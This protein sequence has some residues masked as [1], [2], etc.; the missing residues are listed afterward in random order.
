MTNETA[1][2]LNDTQR[3]IVE[4]YYY[5][6]KEAV[7]LNFISE[8]GKIYGDYLLEDAYQDACYAL[9]IAAYKYNPE[10]K[11][12]AS[13]ETFAKTVIKNYIISITRTQKKYLNEIPSEFLEELTVV[14]DSEENIEENVCDRIQYNEIITLA[15]EKSL[16]D[17]SSSFEMFLLHT[18]MGVK[19]KH[20]A[21]KYDVSYRTAIRKMNYAKKN[22]REQLSVNCA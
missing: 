22:L 9:C 1:I 11:K 21:N 13:F 12:G 18:C 14:S 2:R 17:E 3:K 7:D 10:S 8:D 16:T 5:L 4:D 15:K 6:A 20:L 19:I